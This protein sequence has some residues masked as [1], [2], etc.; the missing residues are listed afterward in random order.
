MKSLWERTN[1]PIYVLAFTMISYAVFI[2]VRLATHDWDASYFV[3]AGDAATNPK[4]APKA[5]Y[6]QRDSAGHD[7]QFYYRLALDPLTDRVTDYG[8][9]LDLPAYRQQRI[10]YPV[11]VNLLSLGNVSAVPFWMIAVNYVGICVIAWV[12]SNYARALGLHAGWGLAFAC[13]PG[14]VLSL[15]RDFAEIIAAAL[16]LAMLWLVRARRPA[17]ATL[18][19]ALAVLARETTA[20]TS[21]SIA[22]AGGWRSWKTRSWDARLWLAVPIVVGVAWQVYLRFNW[23]HFASSDSGTLSLPLVSFVT[24]LADKMSFST[25]QE[26]AGFVQM[27]LVAAFAVA[28]G[29]ALKGATAEPHEKIAWILYAALACVVSGNVWSEDW[30][31]LRNLWELYVFGAIIL[32]TSN[33]RAKTPL[34]ACWGAMWVFEYALRLDLHKA[35]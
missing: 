24:S 29:F 26:I 1:A 4:D 20:L 8:I 3:T 11:I 35:I 31:F 34:F 30:S 9:T 18:F 22:L 2:A 25:G 7:G 5:L 14:F 17:R 33:S 28:A 21:A 23:G 6:V 16:L 10:L 19:G 15:A 12:G 27:L 13:Y 32:M